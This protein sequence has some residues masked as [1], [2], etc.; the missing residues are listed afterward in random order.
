MKFIRF[1]FT[2]DIDNEDYIMSIK[3]KYQD[4]MA[5]LQFIKF[6]AWAV[7]KTGVLQQQKRLA[8]SEILQKKIGNSNEFSE[9]YMNNED[10]KFAQVCRLYCK[11]NVITVDEY[12]PSDDISV[13]KISERTCINGYQ[14]T[15]NDMT[16][17]LSEYENDKHMLYAIYTIEKNRTNLRNFDYH[18]Y[19][20]ETKTSL[21]EFLDSLC[22]ELRTNRNRIHY[23]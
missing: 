14:F 18:A 5:K 6:Y 11:P 1:L 3:C 2:F 19:H 8:E 4:K 21:F 12:I 20:E 22:H 16:V 13:D 10:Y 23:S 15:W 17:V 9:L 7:C